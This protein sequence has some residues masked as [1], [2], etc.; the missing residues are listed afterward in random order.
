MHVA[1]PPEHV[2][3]NLQRH[4]AKVHHLR[5]VAANSILFW[6]AALTNLAA[7]PFLPLG[8]FVREKGTFGALVADTVPAVVSGQV[9][10][11][12]VSDGPIFAFRTHVTI[13]LASLE[14][15]LFVE[16]A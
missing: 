1:V 5:F 13:V 4:S 3:R 10:T 7:I 2:A 16:F 12:R 9:C 15:L 14:L 6:L 11:C 8:N